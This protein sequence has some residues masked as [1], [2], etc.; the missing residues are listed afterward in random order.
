MATSSVA[1]RIL[2]CNAKLY[3]SRINQT[4]I[5]PDISGA[6]ITGPL[7]K[8][9][10]NVSGRHL[11]FCIWIKSHSHGYFLFFQFRQELRQKSW[12]DYQ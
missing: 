2:V 9:F 5:Y 6:I 3:V 11:N 12:K 10:N 7:L 4:G 1:I 8:I